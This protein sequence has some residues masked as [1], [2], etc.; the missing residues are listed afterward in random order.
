VEKMGET[1]WKT[2]EPDLVP[3]FTS[4]MAKKP[5][6]FIV[7]GG[8]ATMANSLKACKT[9]GF[10]RRYQ[11]SCTLPQTMPFSNHSV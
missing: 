2:G 4:V 6:A 11:F 9:T 3:Y 5:D 1:W 8:G 7:C 10:S